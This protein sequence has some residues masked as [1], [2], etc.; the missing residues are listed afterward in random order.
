MQ[1][2]LNES[3]EAEKEELQA[4][5]LELLHAR[6]E[7]K[8]SLAE[9]AETNRELDDFTYAASHDLK[10]PLRAISNLAGF[11]SEELEDVATE[12][13]KQDLAQLEGRA[14]R[15]ERMLSGMLEYSRVTRREHKSEP[16]LARELVEEIAGVL[17]VPAGFRVCFDGYDKPFYTQRSPLTQVIRNLVDNALKHHEGETGK[18]EVVVCDRG[19]A[20]EFRVVDD[21]PGIAPEYQQ[22][23]FGMFETLKR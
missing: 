14:K 11:I 21:G 5:N 15:L 2:Q 22:R 8:E 13:A 17:D 4:K 9:L 3:L 6:D 7:L 18:V 23:V 10:S 19:Y 20:L 12:Q 1:R 16:C